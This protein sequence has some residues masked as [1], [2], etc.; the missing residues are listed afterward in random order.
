MTLSCSHPF[1]RVDDDDKVICQV[2]GKD[3]TITYWAAQ[4]EDMKAIRFPV[5]YDEKFMCIRDSSRGKEG[6]ADMI[7]EF[8]YYFFRDRWGEKDQAEGGITF[9]KARISAI[10][11][12]IAEAIN[13]IPQ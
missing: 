11:H 7:M 5:K 2:C 13:K 10:G 9:D 1:T 6:K 4:S 3:I 8:N 12:A